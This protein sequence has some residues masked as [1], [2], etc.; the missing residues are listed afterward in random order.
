V[1][2]PLPYGAVLTGTGTTVAVL[3][4]TAGELALLVT[5]ALTP[6]GKEAPPV[7][8][9][10]TVTVERATVTVTGA[11]DPDATAPLLPEAE[12]PGEP[13]EPEA[14]GKPAEPEAPGEPAAPP[15]PPAEALAEEAAMTVTYLV[16][17]SVPVMVV[18]GPV[19]LPAPPAAPPGAD[20]EVGL[21]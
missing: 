15:L 11:Q 9:A 20:A 19:E 13:A 7:G 10:V 16:E 12:A 8:D 18:V 1:S 2:V 21:A 17:V 6:P 14:P 4:I 5:W 3:K